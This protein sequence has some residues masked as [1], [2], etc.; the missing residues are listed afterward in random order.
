MRVCSWSALLARP[1]SLASSTSIK[2]VD[3]TAG[4]NPAGYIVVP[5]TPLNC[6]NASLLP[7]P[8]SVVESEISFP[9]NLYSEQRKI[10][11][12]ALTVKGT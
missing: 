9:D 2:L 12:G 11:A 5:P 8:A 4:G 7:V 3:L 1:S 10:G 6:N